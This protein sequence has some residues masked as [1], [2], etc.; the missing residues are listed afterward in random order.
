[1]ICIAFRIMNEES[2]EK[3]LQVCKI[4]Y[5]VKLNLVVEMEDIEA[6]II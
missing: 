2:C 4:P 1:M 6:I 5:T 3:H